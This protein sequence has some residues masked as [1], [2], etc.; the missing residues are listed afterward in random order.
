M[1]TDSEG[2]LRTIHSWVMHTILLKT[3][4]SFWLLLFHV[5]ILRKAPAR[6]APTCTACMG[7][8]W[9]ASV[10]HVVTLETAEMD[11]SPHEKK[12]LESSE[13]NTTELSSNLI[14]MSSP[15][16]RLIKPLFFCLGVLIAQV[17]EEEKC[18]TLSF[19][20]EPGTVSWCTA[21]LFVPKKLL[22]SP[23]WWDPANFFSSSSSFLYLSGK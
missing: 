12:K 10:Q 16:C 21:A 6:A 5:A 8:H 7:G 14:R 20:L 4:H 18:P 2:Y 15:R 9:A 1:F 3:M 19:P 13:L 17:E 22:H 23:P 11:L